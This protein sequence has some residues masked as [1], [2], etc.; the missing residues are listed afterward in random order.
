[1]RRFPILTA[2]TLGASALVTATRLFND[3]PLDALRRDPT[4]LDHGQL[5]RLIS[6]VLVQSD[7]SIVSIIAVF[8]LCAA[9]G[10]YAERFLSP[11]RWLTLYLC[12]AL[13]GHGIGEAFQPLEGGT[14]NESPN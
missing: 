5:W 3:G 12:G 2:A 8:A 10:V 6:P 9:I 4:A 13:V 11:L 1:M 7:S 14:S